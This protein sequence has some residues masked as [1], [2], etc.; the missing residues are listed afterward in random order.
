MPGDGVNGGPGAVALELRGEELRKAGFRRDV[1]RQM[2]L[3]EAGSEV[4]A[5][6][7]AQCGDKRRREERERDHCGDGV[8]RESEEITVAIA[9]GE[10]SE[11]DRATGLHADSG[12]EE[13]GVQVEQRLFDKV[14]SAHGD[15]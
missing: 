1:V 3:D 12:E 14:V 4:F 13:F 15:S 10:A 9:A 2:R 6:L 5:G 7:S 11:D 8:A